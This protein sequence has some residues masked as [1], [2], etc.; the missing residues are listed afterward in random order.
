MANAVY[1]PS[2]PQSQQLG[3]EIAILGEP[4]IRT[5]TEGG[6]AITRPRYTSAPE[7]MSVPITY[8][9]AQK[10]TFDSFF[11]DTI[12][13][14]ADVFDWEDPVDDS[15]REVRFLAIPSF[16]MSSGALGRIWSSTFELE[17]LP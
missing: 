2:L 10:I 16:S 9:Q 7:R 12:N 5:P 6:P 11:E 15:V 3:T 4:S 13:M 1:P 14:G 8:T 17:L